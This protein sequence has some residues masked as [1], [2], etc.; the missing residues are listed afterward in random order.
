MSPTATCPILVHFCCKLGPAAWLRALAQGFCVKLRF[1][2]A[3]PTKMSAWKMKRKSLLARGPN[4]EQRKLKELT[5]IRTG[6]NKKNLSVVW[7]DCQ[8]VNYLCYPNVLVDSLLKFWPNFCRVNH[9]FVSE[10]PVFQILFAL[11]L[12]CTLVLVL[13]NDRNISTQ[14]VKFEST[15]SNMLP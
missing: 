11:L 8:N 9:N 12:R 10:S 6:K 7:I 15:T 2:A 13:A 3:V 5:S 14:M 1:D 4:I